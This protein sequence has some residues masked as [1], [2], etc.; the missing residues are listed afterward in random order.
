MAEPTEREQDDKGLS[1]R[2]LILVFLAAVAV[3]GVFFSLGFLVGYNE[4]GARV[5]PVTEHVTN[6]PLAP[7]IVNPPPE[8]SQTTTPAN[9]PTAP[10]AK[11][12]AA[13]VESKSPGAEAA[14]SP[15][16][17]SPALAPRGGGVESQAEPIPPAA[18]PSNSREVG[19]GLTVQVAASRAKEDAEALVKILK[20]RGYPVFLVAPEYAH[21][22]DNLFRVQ[23][24]PFRT[25]EEA[26]KV[27]KQLAAEGFNSFI[28]R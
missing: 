12:P 8:S 22:N 25:H 11:V 4:R 23:V 19:V 6:P 5:G 24:G 3:C 15:P 2:H 7:P 17:P 14:P 1:A 10:P 21:A 20:A 27:R 16:P 18:P 26:E 28:R 9:A 13:D